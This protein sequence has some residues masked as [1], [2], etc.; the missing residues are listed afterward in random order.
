MEQWSQNSAPVVPLPVATDQD[1][2]SLDVGLD[3]AI[4]AGWIAS[5]CP[6]FGLGQVLV[7]GMQPPLF[8]QE[9]RF[10]ELSE[11]VGPGLEA[12]RPDMLKCRKEQG[13]DRLLRLDA[14]RGFPLSSFEVGFAL[15]EFPGGER[16]RV[17]EDIVEWLDDT[18]LV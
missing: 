18:R 2:G 14:R 4:S 13:V 12:E 11:V 8:G 16:R 6:S 5:L 17:Q 7:D 9:R 3:E 10:D 15:G 1:R